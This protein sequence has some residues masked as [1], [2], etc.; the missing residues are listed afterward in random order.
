M[1]DIYEQT[2]ILFTLCEGETTL[3]THPKVQRIFS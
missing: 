3:I 2:Q 1:L